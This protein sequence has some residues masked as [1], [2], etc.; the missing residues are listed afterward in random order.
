[1]ICAG[2][3]PTELNDDVAY[4]VARG[5]AQFLASAAHRRRARY[6]IVAAPVSPMPCAAA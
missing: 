2:R 5:Y 1:M 3:I 6:P 4:R